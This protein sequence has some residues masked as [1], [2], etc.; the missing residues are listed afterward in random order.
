MST[1]RIVLHVEE[2]GQRLVPS[3]SPMGLLANVPT[4]AQMLGAQ[5]LGAEH[6]T[7]EQ[8]GLHGVGVAVY[9]TTFQVPDTGTQYHLQGAGVFGALGAVT[10]TGDIHSVGFILK[11]QANGTLTFT[12]DQGSVT[13]KLTG[14]VQGSFAHLP[15]EFHYEVTG[16]TGAYQNL[17]DQGTL[18]LQ[19]VASGPGFGVF[20]I[21]I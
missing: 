18:H 1:R 15:Q 10:V 3:A 9:T 2:L 17:H 8:S 4:A 16:G 19:T 5:H 12:N 6:H 21:R 7:A 13:V 11:G 14:P 20:T